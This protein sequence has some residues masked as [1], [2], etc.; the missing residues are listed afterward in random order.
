MYT[1]TSNYYILSENNMGCDLMKKIL[2]L[3]M[4]IFISIFSLGG[5]VPE[6][7]QIKYLNNIDNIQDV[8]CLENIPSASN[9]SRTKEIKGIY[10][11]MTDKILNS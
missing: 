3:I 10:D 1:F 9:Y 8:N 4:I 11:K 7:C 2:F 5:D 6:I